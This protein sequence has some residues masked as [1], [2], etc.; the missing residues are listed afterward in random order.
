MSTTSSTSD[1]T[2]T[3]AT[4]SKHL[5]SFAKAA[6]IYGKS[7]GTFKQKTVATVIGLRAEG[8]D[9][10]VIAIALRSIVEKHGISRQHLNRVLTAPTAEGGAGMEHERK[11]EKSGSGSVRAGL[12]KDA[13]KGGVTVKIGDAHS[14]FAALLAEFDGKHAKVMLLAEKLNELASQGMEAAAKGGKAK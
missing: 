13:A 9:D 4:D 8:Y 6:E 14:L 5:A 3:I 10:K 11:R 7:F 12:A 2:T 1:T